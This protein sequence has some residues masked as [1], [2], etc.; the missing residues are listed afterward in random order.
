MIEC[1]LALGAEMLILGQAANSEMDAREKLRAAIS[2]GRGARVFERM[3]EAQGGDPRVVENPSLLPEAPAHV[4]VHAPQEG[5]VAG[6]D[7]LELGLTAVAM[8][9]GRTRADQPVDHAVGIEVL[10]PRGTTVAAGQGLARLHVR[11]HAAGEAIL[12]RVQK[13]FRIAHAAETTTPLV[14][15]RIG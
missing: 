15:G 9:A 2:S 7:C 6:I 14:L 11:T 13:A 5:F 4:V 3:I 12:P 8:G 10:A 1:T